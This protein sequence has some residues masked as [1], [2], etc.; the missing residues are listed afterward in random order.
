MAFNIK[1]LILGIG[2][3]VIFG[4]AL[5]QGIEAFYPSPQYDDFCTPGRFEAYYPLKTPAV[6]ESC[7]YTQELRD[8]EA[9]CYS[10]KGQPIYEYDDKGCYISVREC[11][12]CQRDFEEAQ[13][14]H[15]KIVFIIAV[16]IG[17]ITLIIG[18]GVLSV[19][20]V[21]SALIG[22]G[23]WAIFW[24]SAI[25]WRN[26]SNIWRFLLLLAALILI[27]WFALRLNKKKEKG[28]LARV[29]LKR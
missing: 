25:N 4:L 10:E 9:R 13:D 26:F 19:E 21:G 11:D 23:I 14:A 22:S 17:V 15:S 12:Y 3:V 27:V 20:P 7:T 6:G 24:G 5:W 1:N 8:A 16:I 18:Y 29:G 2:I 28:F